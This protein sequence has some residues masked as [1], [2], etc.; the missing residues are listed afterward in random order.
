VRTTAAFK[1]AY[2][3][4]QGAGPELAE[5]ALA[6]ASALQEAGYSL[7]GERRL[8]LPSTGNGSGNIK[9]ELQIGIQ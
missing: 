1:C 2:T 4:L 7:S 3:E 9:V 8:V 5:Q 6:F